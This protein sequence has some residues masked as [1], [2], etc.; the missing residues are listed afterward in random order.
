FPTTVAASCTCS[1]FP[2]HCFVICRRLHPRSTPFPYTTLFRSDMSYA[3]ARDSDGG[4]SDSVTRIT[5]PPFDGAYL[6]S[7]PTMRPATFMR[8]SHDQKVA[9]SSGRTLSYHTPPPTAA[10]AKVHNPRSRADS[11]PAHAAP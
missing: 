10:K 6:T 5:T 4:G 1:R 9:L 11:T 2:A 8:T 7:N 3:C